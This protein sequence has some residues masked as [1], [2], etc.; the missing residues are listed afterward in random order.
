MSLSVPTAVAIP[1]NRA[2]GP[3]HG[4]QRLASAVAAD[5]PAHGPSCDRQAARGAGQAGRR[6]AH[7][8]GPS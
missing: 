5:P 2:Y 7:F 3:D 8:G 4:Q 1:G 6:V